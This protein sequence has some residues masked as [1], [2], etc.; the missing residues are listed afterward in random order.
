M[1]T[2]LPQPNFPSPPRVPQMNGSKEFVTWVGDIHR[3]LDAQRRSLT[4]A[5]WGLVHQTNDSVQTVGRVLD[6]TTNPQPTAITPE[7]PIHH[8]SGAGSIE[9]INPPA[10]LLTSERSSG[11]SGP[12]FL[13]ADGAWSLVTPATIAG[14]IATA[15]T[16]TVGK[17]L[18]VVYDPVQ[19]LWYP[20]GV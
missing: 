8:V 14:N 19:K 5:I 16:A 20:V 13:I 12:I 1:N 11:F 3:Y 15:A 7:H 17:V 6:S 4:D 2:Q 10:P 18:V 9:T